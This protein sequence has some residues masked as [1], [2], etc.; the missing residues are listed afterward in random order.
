LPSP[1]IAMLI[2]AVLFGAFTAYVWLRRGNPGAKGLMLALAAGVLYT[3]TYALELGTVGSAKQTWG[4]VKYIGVGLL[5]AAWLVFTLQYTGRARWVTRRLLLLL[6]VEPL[7]VLTLLAIPR[8]HDL[9]H[10]YPPDATEQF[11]VVGLGPAGWIN[12]FYSYGLLLFGTGLFVRTLSGIAR[13]YRKQA[14]ALIA[15]LFLPLLFN[16][17]YNFNVGPF[18]RVDL[19]P[20][21]FVLAVVVVVWGIFRLRLLDIVPVARSRIVETMQDGVVVLDA[22]QRIVDLNPAAQRI[23][24]HTAKQ[25]VG[26]SLEQLLPDYANLLERSEGSPPVQS[27]IRLHLGSALRH[28]EITLSPIPDD[29]GRE[30]GKLM[31]LRDISERKMTEERLEQMAH[32]DSLTG[33]PNRK[34]FADRLSQAIIR[35]RRNHQLVGLLFLDIDYFKDVNDTLGHEVGD[36]L[37]QQLATRLRDCARAEDTVARLSG[38]EF[39]M[40][41]PEMQAPTDAA[42]VATRIMESLQSPLVAGGHEL[43]MSA[44][45]GICVWPTDGEDPGTLIRNADLAMYRAKAQ[46]RNRF[47]FYAT[48][49]GTHAARRLELEQDLRRALDRGE[50]RLHYQPIVSLRTREVHSLEALIRWQHPRRGLILP[51]H[52]L[53]RAEETGLIESI[54]EWVLEKACREALTW[55]KTPDGRSTTVSVNVSARQLKRPGFSSEVGDVLERTGL[56]PDRLILEISEGTVMDDAFTAAAILHDLKGLGVSLSLDDFGTGSTSLSQ[57][58][59]FPLDVLKIDRLFI[60]G[61]G[62]GSEDTIIVQAML[63]LAHALGLTVVAEGV[64]TEGQMK[65]LEGLECDLVQGFLISQPL[66]NMSVTEFMGVRH[67]AH[68]GIA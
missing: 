27:E 61:L 29:R 21:A 56:E 18:G 3:A 39:T 13:P 64:E 40:I 33:L 55:G 43:Y 34:L 62:R 11:P 54:G 59:R 26:L 44:S 1:S 35:A 48:D 5:P 68:L 8:T 66:P 65:I 12:L 7:V 17:L 19:T 60:R 2:G 16:V 37:L 28:Y 23:L 15:A 6:S 24:G 45:L 32:Y 63:S 53:W 50:L 42:I 41:L 20:F 51:S 49:F 58:G 4:D 36:L 22:Y 38:D 30:S 57:F 46:G 47:E 67:R 52:F 14:R 10:F 9:V 25:S 31:V